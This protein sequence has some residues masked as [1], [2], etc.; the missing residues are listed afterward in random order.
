M[1]RW[2]TLPYPSVTLPVKLRQNRPLLVQVPFAKNCGGSV[3]GHQQF[4]TH[5]HR[6][7]KVFGVQVSEKLLAL[8]D[9]VIE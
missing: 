3:G 7:A 9:G 1:R 2:R 4:N 8:A 5:P 6:T